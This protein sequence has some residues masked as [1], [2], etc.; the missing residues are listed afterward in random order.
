MLRPWLRHLQRPLAAFPKRWIGVQTPLWRERQQAIARSKA[1]QPPPP[2]LGGDPG[3]VASSSSATELLQSAYNAAEEDQEFECS[4]FVWTL[5]SRPRSA[6][7]RKAIDSSVDESGRSLLQVLSGKGLVRPMTYLLDMQANVA[8][9][10]SSG[11]TALHATAQ[12]DQSEAALLLL[13]R[14]RAPTNVRNAMGDTPLH[15]A[16]D[17]NSRAMVKMLM[18]FGADP[19]CLDT[20]P[21]SDAEAQKLVDWSKKYSERAKQL[22]GKINTVRYFK[23]LGSELP[24]HLVAPK[25]V[26][27]PVGYCPEEDGKVVQLPRGIRYAKK[28]KGPSAPS[29]K[30]N[31]YAIRG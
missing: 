5:K 13:S 19:S 4:C 30:V 2:F 15:L 28:R 24:S 6:E 27:T 17:K 10:D 23:A 18:R 25:L 22:I 21:W 3:S 26:L 11:F 7:I 16:I 31:W 14:G 9:R 8:R 1:L 12:N 20:R 29:G